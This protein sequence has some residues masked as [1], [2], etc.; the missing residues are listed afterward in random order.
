MNEVVNFDPERKKRQ[1]SYDGGGNGQDDRLRQVELDIRELKAEKRHLAM[2]EDLLGAENRLNQTMSDVK[3]T[4]AVL[5]ERVDAIKQH[6][7]SKGFILTTMIAV[8]GLII[9]ALK[10]LP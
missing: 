9:A 5:V 4:L 1:Q 8:A 3:T 7:A 6:Y 10:L 2:K